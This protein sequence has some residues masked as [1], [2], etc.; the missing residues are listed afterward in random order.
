MKNQTQRLNAKTV[1]ANL[2]TGKHKFQSY[3]RYEI[4]WR[5]QPASVGALTG[6]ILEWGNR[7]GEA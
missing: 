2:Y 4:Q 7:R 1:K 6:T 3:S 5:R